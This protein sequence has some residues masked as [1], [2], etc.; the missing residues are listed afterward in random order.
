MNCPQC[1]KTLTSTKAL[2]YHIMHRV[3]DNKDKLVCIQ[4]GKR[5]ATKSGYLYHTQN[6]VCQPKLTNNDQPKPKLKLKLKTDQ[7]YDDMEK[8]ELREKLRKAELVIAQMTGKYEAL[9]ENPQKIKNNIIVF[10][11]EFGKED[12][13]YIQQKLGDI[14]GPMITQ[15]P[16]RSIP[17]LFNKIHNNDKLPEYHNV[18]VA[19]ERSKY[20]LISDGTSFIYHPKKTIIDQII[21]DK[22]HILNTYV[23]ANGEQLGEKV[24]T[25]YE[26]Y[27]NQLDDDSSFRKD[28]ELEIGGLLLN[29]KSVI[30]NDEHTRKLLDKVNEGNFELE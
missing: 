18:Y 6:Q 3:C 27:Q 2:N 19:S 7:R 15:H 22:R 29:M 20:A 21:E 5:L 12:M 17:I 24:L 8:E 14:L 30:A 16:F 13:K 23:D 11:K 25:K 26:R 28:L 9:R 4:C 10:P 1:G